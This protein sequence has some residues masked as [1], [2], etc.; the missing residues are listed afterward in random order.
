METIGAQSIWSLLENSEVSEI[1]SCTKIR[2]DNGHFVASYLELAQK[3]AD[4]QFRNRDHVLL[5]RGQ[6]NDRRN[7]RNLTTLKPTLFRPEGQKLRLSLSALKLRFETLFRAEDYLVSE[8]DFEGVLG[9]ERIRRHQIIRWSIIQHYNICETPLLDLTQSLRIA[10]SFASQRR[11]GFA[12]VFV[13]GVP[14]ISG[15]VTASDEG[16]LQTVRL[17]SACPPSALRPHIQE[18]FLVGEYPGMVGY[19]QAREYKPVE[20]DF[21][22]RLIAK[23]KF[24]PRAFW[25]VDDAFPKISDD[26]LY[27]DDQDPF[28]SIAEEVI[29]QLKKDS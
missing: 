6:S 22:R 29:T 9:I 14:N 4:L 8:C 7:A 26:A 12:Y 5:F 27:P 23:F 11:R 28:V 15:A 24:R 18:G 16:G 13:L 21:G 1:A 2:K 25:R 17:A 3:V 20:I 19:S 10:A